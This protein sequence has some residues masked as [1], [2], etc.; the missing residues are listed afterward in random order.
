MDA[1][2]FHN[3]MYVMNSNPL[4]FSGLKVLFL[5]IEPYGN[6][7][8]GGW[9]IQS[10][11]AVDIGDFLKPG[12]REDLEAGAAKWKVGKVVLVRGVEEALEK[13]GQREI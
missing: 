12:E 9:E 5:V 8:V 6:I 7:G 4:V 13:V 3:R 1:M 10:D 11:S 2:E